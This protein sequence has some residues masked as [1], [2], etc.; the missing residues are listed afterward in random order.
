[1]EL[2]IAQKLDALLT[3]QSIDSQ[4]DVLQTM[5]GDLPEEVQDLEDEIAGY[6]TR[7][8]KFKKEISALEDEISHHKQ[9]KKEADKLI[10][11]YKDQQ[12]NVRNNREYDAISKEI[13]LQELEI[14]LSDKKIGEANFKISK[15]NEEIKNTDKISS[16]RQKDLD[17]KKKELNVLVSESHEEEQKLQKDREKKSALV[18][19]RLLKSYNKI[20]SNARNGLAVVVVKRGACGGCF[21]M[22]PP[23]RQ[24]EIREKKKIIVCEHCGKIFADVEEI[25]PPPEKEKATPTKKAAKVEE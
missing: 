21:N 19:D 5:R 25:I 10:A 2:T 16:E 11:K 12:M 1:M 4:L 6:E 17:T 24:A 8:G 15:K 23:Q 18:E 13:E 3:L 7:I 22:V 14:E 9:A 20:R